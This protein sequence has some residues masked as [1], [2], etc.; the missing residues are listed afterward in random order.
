MTKRLPL[1]TSLS[2]LLILLAP[3]LALAEQPVPLL[4]L[5]FETQ[6]P[7]GNRLVVAAYLLDPAGNPISDQAVSFSTDAEFMNT[8]GDV[9]IGEAITNDN[10]LAYILYVPKSLGEHTITARFAGN[11]VFAPVSASSPVTVTAG[12]TTL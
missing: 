3:A 12:P 4:S 7:A 5:G 10:G 8:V 6:A 2:L 9:S 11:E 1:I